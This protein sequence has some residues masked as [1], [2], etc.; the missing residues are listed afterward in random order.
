MTA[1]TM[2]DFA[3]RLGQVL[4]LEVIDRTGLEREVDVRVNWHHTLDLFDVRALA[5]MLRSP[6]ARNGLRLD[7]ILAPRDVLVIEHV[8]MPEG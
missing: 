3:A 4:G 6:L 1:A 2:S 7:P 5:E 8:E